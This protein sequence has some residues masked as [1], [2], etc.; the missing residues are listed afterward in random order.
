MF[1]YAQNEVCFEIESNPYPNSSSL[2]CF[3]KYI[4]VLDCFDVYAEST[5]SDDKVLHVAAVIAELLDNDED[6]EV[7]DIALKNKLNQD[8]VEILQILN[9]E[10]QRSEMTINFTDF[11]S[12]IS[13]DEFSR[14]YFLFF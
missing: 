1:L 3:T 8:L 7:D 6:G 14:F 9:S 13:S 4:R 12:V 5:V 11:L 10:T 2:G